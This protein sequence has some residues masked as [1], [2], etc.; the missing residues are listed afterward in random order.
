[1]KN[2]RSYVVGALLAIFALVSINGIAVATTGDG[3]ILGSSNSANKVTTLKRTTSGAVLNLNATNGSPPLAVNSTVRVKNLNADRVDGAKVGA[4]K[5]RV[6]TYSLPDVT[7]STTQSISFSDL[8]PGQYLATYSIATNTQ[9]GASFDCAF[10]NSGASHYEL[11][12]RTV[13]TGAVATVSGSGVIDTTG[14]AFQFYC[15][16]NQNFNWQVDSPNYST[17]S[18]LRVDSAA[19]S[20]A[21]E[22][23]QASAHNAEAN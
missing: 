8:P 3:L 7:A 10:Y 1:M 20:E 13:A 4:L 19:S 2:L 15:F 16:S 21:S 18:F 6:Y 14:G 22:F 9:T 23:R 17:V 12:A 11:D 5:N